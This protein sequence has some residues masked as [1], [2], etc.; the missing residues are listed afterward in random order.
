MLN[1]N[2]NIITK[3]EFLKYSGINLDLELPNDDDRGSEADRFIH[4]T[5]LFIFGEISKYVY[6]PINDSNKDLFKIALME[7][8]KYALING[9]DVLCKASKNYLR[10]G[11]FMNIPRG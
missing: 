10:I 6:N 3:E 7:Q 2:E 9:N 4:F 11:G 1:M 5:Q 8:M